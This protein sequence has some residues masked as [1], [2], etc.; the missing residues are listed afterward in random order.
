[1]IDAKTEVFLG[2]KQMHKEEGNPLWLTL[3][4][5]GLHEK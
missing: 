4:C 5:P 3:S 2:W 1:M